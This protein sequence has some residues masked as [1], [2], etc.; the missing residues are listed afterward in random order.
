LLLL[1]WRTALYKYLFE[2]DM[3]DE[4]FIYIIVALNALVQLM[5][6]W[7][8]KFLTGGKWKYCVLVVAIP[9]L[10]MA[11]MRLLVAGGVIHGRVADQSMVERIIT[12]GASVLLMAGPWLVT[13]AAILDKPRRRALAALNAQLERADSHPP[14]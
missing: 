3:S 13:I 11:S 5:L 2:T 10:I 1:E 7:R 12:M 14:K 8:L 6:I 9:I 4:L